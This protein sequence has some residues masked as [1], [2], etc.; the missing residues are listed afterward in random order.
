[1]RM[2]SP[3]SV[4]ISFDELKT[5][6]RKEYPMDKSLTKKMVADYLQIKPS[7]LYNPASYRD[8]DLLEKVVLELNNM[9][10]EN[11]RKYAN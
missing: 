4:I 1:M 11:L 8:T 9:D 6:Y 2:L 5:K 7:I 3:V 10:L